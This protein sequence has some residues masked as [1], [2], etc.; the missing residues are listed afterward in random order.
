M[1]DLEKKYHGKNIEFVSISIDAKKDYEKW[2]K[3]VEEKELTGIQL[4]ADKE[5]NSDFV[6]EYSIRGIPH[7]IL[8][9]PDGNIVRSSAPMPGR[10][11]EIKE[12]F[13]SLN[14]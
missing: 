5:Q 11:E 12:L 14:L 9:D 3:M 10:I 1:K 7:F 4:L 13:N 2:R 8:I 6:Q